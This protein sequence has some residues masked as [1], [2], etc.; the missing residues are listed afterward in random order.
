MNALKELKIKPKNDAILVL[1]N[2]ATKSSSEIIAPKNVSN[3]YFAIKK[4]LILAQFF[5]LMPIRGLKN[6]NINNINFKW[7]SFNTVYS[8]MH[9]FMILVFGILY[10]AEFLREEMNFS[11]LGK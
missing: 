1:S 8:I 7:A 4:V 3:F 6:D 11:Y 10:F 5:G 2:E 9:A